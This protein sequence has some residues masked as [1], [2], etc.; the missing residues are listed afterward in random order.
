MT[1]KYYYYQLSGFKYKFVRVFIVRRRIG[2]IPDIFIA[3]FEHNHYC[4]LESNFF[5]STSKMFVL[6]AWLPIQTRKL[7]KVS[8]VNP[9]TIKPYP[10]GMGCIMNP[11]KTF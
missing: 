1:F 8:Y 3:D 4:I 5:F 6:A 7:F 9:R 2:F 10:L 11:R